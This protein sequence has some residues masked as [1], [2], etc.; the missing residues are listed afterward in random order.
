MIKALFSFSVYQSSYPA[1]A[2]GRGHLGRLVGGMGVTAG[3]AGLGAV[4]L[5]LASLGAGIGIVDLERGA[6]AEGIGFR[7]FAI[8]AA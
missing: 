4:D 8:L 1:I 3:S 2:I 7:E 6:G 5:D